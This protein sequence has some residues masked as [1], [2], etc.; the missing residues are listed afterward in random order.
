MILQG[1]SA[2]SDTL[3][4]TASSEAAEALLHR[5]IRAESLFAFKHRLANA[6]DP[7]AS[8]RPTVE[9]ER[10]IRACII[11]TSIEGSAWSA[12]AKIATIVRELQSL[13]EELE[14]PKVAA[15]FGALVREALRRHLDTEG[16]H[17]LVRLVHEASP[18]R[19]VDLSA[20]E[21]IVRG[22]YRF[23][24]ADLA[25]LGALQSSLARASADVAIEVP[26]ASQQ[27]LDF[28][29]S[30]P[31]APLADA[32]A[33]ALQSPPAF[34]ESAAVLGNAIAAAEAGRIACVGVRDEW[35]AAEAVVARVRA[36]FRVSKITLNDVVVVVSDL[37]SV[38]LPPLLATLATHG[39]AALDPRGF[40][41]ERAEVVWAAE[42]LADLA[43]SSTPRELAEVFASPAI[44]VGLGAAERRSLLRRLRVTSMVELPSFSSF[45]RSEEDL[46][47]ADR[48]D[49][50]TI[51][52]TRVAE[53][54]TR[55]ESV[56][57][58]SH[59][60][61][62]FGLAR[63]ADRGATSALRKDAAPDPLEARELHVV[64]REGA[65][66]R[67]LLDAVATYGAAL[68]RIGAAHSAADAASVAR[69]I[70]GLLPHRLAPLPAARAGMLR[71]A[72]FSEAAGLGAKYVVVAD[73]ARDSGRT[74]RNGAKP[75]E[76][77][78]E[79][80][81]L[82]HASRKVAFVVPRF[83]AGEEATAWEEIATAPRED[84][85]TGPLVRL[86]SAGD[87]ASIA[88]RA[89]VESERER[90]FLSPKRATSAAVGR[91]PPNTILSAYVATAPSAEHPTGTGK[92]MPV[93]T[94]E[95]FA[96]C[97]FR[98][99]A[100]Y[101]LAAR[102]KPTE[103]L[104]L[105]ARDEGALLHDLCAE[106]F[107]STRD[108]WALR[109]RP[110]AKILD[111]LEAVVA[112]HLQRTHIGSLRRVELGY[113]RLLARQVL[114]TSILDDEW[115]FVHAE[116]A[117]GA[118]D[119]S[120]WPALPL[121]AVSAMLTGR[122]DR[123]DVSRDRKSHRVIDYKRG[124][125]DDKLVGV[126]ALQLPLYA[127]VVEGKTHL[128]VLEGTYWR[129]VGKDTGQKPIARKTWDTVKES[130]LARAEETFARAREGLIEPRPH[131]PTTCQNCSA[132][133]VCR[134]PPFAIPELAGDS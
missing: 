75:W 62:A 65:F 47:G 78:A 53:A 34:V 118:K 106:A 60:W 49:E 83:L 59:L 32:A 11:G 8:A 1:P 64:G 81:G 27:R 41:K 133:G 89:R 91:L 69:E 123:I 122:I 130:A 129:L 30:D 119:D 114:L 18:M 115:D 37:D 107:E 17:D 99:Y 16:K 58:L 66:V 103:S 70:L 6:L 71:I 48:T 4:L 84:G 12:R 113:A 127:R 61:S 25:F 43:T 86:D 35:G 26:G 88:E 10:F 121:P 96:T 42:R 15:G 33:K 51:A 97:A 56:A 9:A 72:T 124:K 73:A 38:V 90:Y 93:T 128:P 23:T 36:C 54:A 110:A 116:Q 80:W 19:L 24:P 7:R 14:A 79:L 134:R 29:Q 31:F 77:A 50:L 44:D 132:S 125:Q 46:L 87:V 95:S 5:G 45:L 74:P 100:E 94:L 13:D 109:P 112:A 2:A 120:S 85:E 57:A 101:V 68:G 39:I 22:V 76:F 3:V 52:V 67:A 104:T 105:D 20:R 108:L 98:G 102:D 21:V 82:V 55:G 92:A 111:A 117:F 126:T 131:L 63:A 28:S 40:E